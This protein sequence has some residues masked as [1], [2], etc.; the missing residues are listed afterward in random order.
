[1]PKWLYSATVVGGIVIAALNGLA[2]A[3]YVPASTAQAA[4]ELLAAAVVLMRFRP[5]AGKSITDL[6]ASTPN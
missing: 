6:Q 5:S 2:Q 4:S 1:M 3:G